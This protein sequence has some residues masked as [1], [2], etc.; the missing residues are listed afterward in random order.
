MTKGLT[1][2]LW[3]IVG[4]TVVTVA[5]FIAVFWMRSR[6]ADET[7]VV[8]GTMMGLAVTFVAAGLTCLC[9]SEIVQRARKERRKRA[10]RRT[11]GN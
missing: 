2:S 9:V 8:I 11:N 7:V 1:F 10:F 4:T 3:A 5:I 6:G